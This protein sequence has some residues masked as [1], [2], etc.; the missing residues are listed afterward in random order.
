MYA[1]SH[2][3]I[4]EYFAAQALATGL[5]FFDENKWREFS[6]LPA[7]HETFSIYFELMSTKKLAKH[8]VDQLFGATNLRVG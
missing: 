1:F 2:L 3:G 4:Q 7:L 8:S 5:E 6:T